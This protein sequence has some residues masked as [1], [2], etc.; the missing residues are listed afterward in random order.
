MEH[1]PEVRAVVR[2]WEAPT[3]PQGMDD[4]MMTRYLSRRRPW[5]RRRLEFRVAIPLP[6]AATLLL[7]AAAWWGYQARTA[8]AFREHM[9]NFEPV[10]SPVITIAEAGR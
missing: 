2:K 3:A 10:A 7:L 5:W 9:N 6:I 8:A 4:R 1:D